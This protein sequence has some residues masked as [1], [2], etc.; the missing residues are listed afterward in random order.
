MRDFSVFFVLDGSFAVGWSHFLW[1]VTSWFIKLLVNRMVGKQTSFKKW[2]GKKHP[3]S[4][5]A[6]SLFACWT[7]TLVLK[8]A[9]Q[10]SWS[11]QFGKPQKHEDVKNSSKLRL[12]LVITLHLIFCVATSSASPLPPC[13]LLSCCEWRF[14][15]SKPGQPHYYSADG[16]NLRV[17]LI[18]DLRAQQ[19]LGNSSSVAGMDHVP[20]E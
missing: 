8:G 17:V 1:G 20:E 12:W 14:W 18:T 3:G 9:F 6:S 10:L 15:S 13:P 2:G 7:Q 11:D 4:W 5:C 19:G 16:N